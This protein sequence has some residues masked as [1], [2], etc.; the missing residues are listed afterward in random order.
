MTR[1]KGMM[2]LDTFT[3]VIDECAENGVGEVALQFYGEPLLHP[4]F[5]SFLKLAKQ[6]GLKVMFDT[7]GFLLSSEL[8]QKILETNIDNVT[9]SFHGV[10][11]ETYMRLHGCDGFNLVE[12]NV[13]GL[14]A[15]RNKLG[16]KTGI[17]V[18]TMM[19]DVT[20]LAVNDDIRRIFGSSVSYSIIN[21]LYSGSS[22]EDHRIVKAD[23]ERD[24]PCSA[25]LNHLAVLWNGDITVCCADFNGVLVLGNLASMTLMEAWHSRKHRAYQMA[26]LLGKYDRM[27]LC[28]RCISS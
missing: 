8:A 14:V 17:T 18:Q 12:K 10:N 28:Q 23:F 16:S 21:C 20:G 11:R 19:S 6:A 26:H 27:P 3:K 9:V 2:S 13:S 22:K 25:L 7:N 24:K 1:E 5:T 4:N 15:L